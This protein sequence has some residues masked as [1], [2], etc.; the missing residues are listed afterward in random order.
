MSAPDLILL[1]GDIRTQD[2]ARPRAEALAAA[3]GRIVAVGSNRE[4]ENLAGPGAETIDLEGR[5]ALP[6]FHDS[7]IHF[8]A[9]SLGLGRLELSGA[10]S[11]DS[12]LK[13]AA[14][15]AAGSAGDSWIL[16]QGWNE[17]AWPENR[18]PTAD[19]LER[20]APG[21][22][23]L[24]YR[25]DLHMALAS[26]AALNLA[27]IE[28]STPDP[29]EGVI[30]RDAAGRPNGL[31]RESAADLVRDCLLAVSDDDL[32]SAVLVGQEKMHAAGVTG[33]VD[34]PLPNDPQGAAQSLRVWRMLK[35]Q[36]RLRLRVAAGLSGDSLD[37]A[38]EQGLLTGAGDELLRLGPVKFFAD[39]GMG[40]RTAWMID[41]YQD[42]GT[43]M[44]LLDMEF[45][46]RQ[47]ARADRAGLAVMIHAIGDR[48]NRE[49]IG[50]FE[51]LGQPPSGAG[52]AVP[53]RIEHLQ[54]IRP[55]DAARLGRLNVAACMQP[56]NLPLDINM[57]DECGG[58]R[59]RDAYAF[60]RLME[61]GVKVSFSSD[62]P[63]C[64]HRPL[65][66][67][68]AAVTRQRP[69]GTPAGGWRPEQKIG[70]DE[71]VRAYTAAPAEMNGWWS[72][73]GALKPGK[74]A[75]LAVLSGNIYEIDPGEIPSVAVDL[76]VFDGRAVFRR[77]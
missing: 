67:I 19:D 48:A 10:D 69:D 12:F 8:S 14:E 9:W 27:G 18:Q 3:A 41:P 71:A 49:V 1:N 21:R 75:D 53:H 63:V 11:F 22:L 4:M 37:Q 44:A 7:H 52:P 20:V 2:Q 77:F 39:G 58:E 62:A 40:A 17:A 43:G 65:L 45:L 66:G 31:L 25:C 70:L 23:I 16:G 54:I 24:L 32:L 60:R 5:L 35:E 51:K 55:E 29:P 36:G 33:L 57:I 50:I 34:V 59:A 47:A 28:A 74:R 30:L 64:D 13:M 72:E 76:T 42:G 68:H 15:A 26:R 38:L 56:P 61:T 46:A 73:A 6:G